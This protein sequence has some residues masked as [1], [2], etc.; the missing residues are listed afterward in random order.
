M[1]RIGRLPVTVPAGVNVSVDEDNTV[2]VNGPKGELSQKIHKD[3]KVTVDGNVI[4]VERPSDQ[5]MHASLHGLS[6]SLI[7]NM[8]NGVTSGFEKKLQIIGVGYKASLS[9]T[10]L[11]LNVGYSHPVEIE[12]PQGI[13]FEVPTPDK[14]S[15]KGI[16]RQLVGAIAAKIREVRSPEPYKGK[17]IRYENEYVIHK[18]GKTGK[19]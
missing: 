7:A 13:K 17:G 5:K 12:A 11:V 4:K 10:K 2:H 18:E 8:V 14:V 6:R 15:V 16:D 19:K 9:G 3:M 1:S